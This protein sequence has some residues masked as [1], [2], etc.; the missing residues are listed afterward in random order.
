MREKH[1]FQFKAG[2]IAA[3]AKAEAEYHRKRAAYWQAEQASALERL[4]ASAKI[5]VKEQHVTGGVRPD[6]TLDFGDLSAQSRMYEAF[7]KWHQHRDAADK[8]EM[9]AKVY[10]T[11]GERVYEMETAD[12]HHFR[13]GGGPHEE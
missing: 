4:K 8:F 1:L 7:N 9:D 13:L 3:A 5:I 12:V 10:G 6:V 2:E 11:Q